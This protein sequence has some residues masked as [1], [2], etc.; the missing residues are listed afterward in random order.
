MQAWHF[1][2][3]SCTRL[4][5]RMGSWVPKTLSEALPDAKCSFPV[6]PGICCSMDTV[7]SHSIRTLRNGLSLHFEGGSRSTCLV[8]FPLYGWQRQQHT[9]LQIV[10]AMHGKKALN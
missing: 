6:C 2:S 3:R 5:V 4:A 1:S 8:C 7:I 9:L 10:L